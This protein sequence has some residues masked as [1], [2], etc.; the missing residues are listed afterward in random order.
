MNYEVA[1]KQYLIGKFIQG[2]KRSPTELELDQLVKHSVKNL[3]ALDEVGFS[4]YLIDKPQFSSY[5]SAQVENENRT[6][7]QLD[8]KLAGQRTQLAMNTMESLFRGAY[9][10]TRV[11]KQELTRIEN[12]LD[13][14]LLLFGSEDAFVYGVE[15]DFIVQDKIDFSTTDAS[16]EAG[17]VTIGRDGFGLVDISDAKIKFTSTSDKGYMG[18]QVTSSVESLKTD[19]GSFWEYLVYTGYK[20]GRVSLMIDVVLPEEQLISELRFTGAT[21]GI[22]SQTLVTGFTSTDGKTFSAI[23]PAEV[24]LTTSESVL[25]IGQT[26]KTVRLLLSKQSYDTATNLANQFVYTFALDSIKLYSESYSTTATSVLYSGPYEVF[27]EN[28]DAV[29]F[30]KATAS[31][32]LVSGD[33]DS[34]GLFLS[35]DGT[36]YVSVDPDS[37]AVVSFLNSSG[38]GTESVVDASVSATKLVETTLIDL[39]PLEA[40]LNT[41]VASSWADKLIKKSVVLKRNVPAYDGQTRIQVYGVD[42]GWFYDSATRSYTTTVYITNPDGF[43]L[44]VGNTSLYV[45]EIQM[46][47][48]VKLQQGYT[49]IRTTESNYH[50]VPPGLNKLS[51]LRK[52]DPLYPYNHK[53]L[54]EGYVYPDTFKGERLYQGVEE[55]FGLLSKYV[56]PELF[57]SSDRDND[58]SVFTIEKPSDAVFKVKADKTD[59]TWANETTSVSWSIARG[60]SN[61]LWLKLVFTASEDYRSSVVKSVQMRVI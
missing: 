25:Q 2:N 20:Q 32:C 34:V 47:G 56:P 1:R 16:V 52:A 57:S 27:D 12:R 54:I 22:N 14:L 58:L 36:N 38:A 15:E 31:L 61:R 37:N 55:Y 11:L 29:N 8:T 59:G 30:T 9:A 19:D 39:D 6:A 26:I 17:Y 7:L 42:S 50:V 46:T 60:P 13:N 24:P 49:V 18:T 3:P 10:S 33:T 44:D 35:N 45:N 40:V 23:E 53:L 28:G 41:S 4:G 43:T 48:L 5:S 21:S 51:D